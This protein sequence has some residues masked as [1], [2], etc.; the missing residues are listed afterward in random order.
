MSS[1]PDRYLAA[2]EEARERVRKAV[3][4]LSPMEERLGPSL[5]PEEQ[6][7]RFDR[8]VK[9]HLLA[10]DTKPVLEWIARNAPPGS[11]PG[12]E[13]LKLVKRFGGA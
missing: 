12:T 2:T 7:Q 11:D 3:D 5:S 6:Q 9:P 4:S 10:G 13:L 8:L 1:Y